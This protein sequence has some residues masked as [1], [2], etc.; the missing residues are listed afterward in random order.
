M[1]QKAGPVQQNVFVKVVHFSNKILGNIKGS[2][3][4]EIFSKKLYSEK[5]RN[6]LP[7]M[8]ISIK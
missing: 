5:K 3:K 7:F 1:K 6:N 8:K 2:I 4:F